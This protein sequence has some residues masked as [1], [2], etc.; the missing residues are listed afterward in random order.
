MKNAMILLGLWIGIILAAYSIA[1]V[2]SGGPTPV[3][4]SSLARIANRTYVDPSG[5]F[6]LVVPIGWR[7]AQE[8]NLLH[9]TDPLEK[10]DAWIVPVDDMAAVRAIETAWERAAPCFE[11]EFGSFSEMTPVEPE[12]R[13]VRIDYR[14]ASDLLASGAAHVVRGGTI[15]LLVRGDLATCQGREAD[16]L[17]G[18][19]ETLTVPG[20]L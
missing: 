18:L 1:Y 14:A 19:E 8:G 16:D 12:I 20:G 7:T 9:L 17:E 4:L 6:E 5:R 2:D 13:K 15:V 10:V 11:K 3:E